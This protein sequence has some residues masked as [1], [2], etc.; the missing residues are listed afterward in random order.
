MHT[1][2]L[3]SRRNIL[4]QKTKHAQTTRDG[5]Q[6][7]VRNS[8]TCC[9]I[10]MNLQSNNFENTHMGLYLAIYKITY[11]T[12]NAFMRVTLH[13]KKKLPAAEPQSPSGKKKEAD[14]PKL[15]PKKPAYN[16]SGQLA[17]QAEKRVADKKKLDAEEICSDSDSDDEDK[18]EDV[19]DRIHCWV[20]L[21]KGAKQ[22]GEW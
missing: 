15:I 22:V 12:C 10:I 21:K 3:V 6:C 9:N 2:Y 8:F 20:L 11:C 7:K 18:D 13:T 1:V 14:G 19:V 4:R 17:K 5:R 16:K